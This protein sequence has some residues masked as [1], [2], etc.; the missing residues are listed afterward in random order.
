MVPRA[1]LLALALSAC[2]M[3]R[4][5]PPVPPGEWQGTTAGDVPARADVPAATAYR[6]AWRKGF[7]RGIVTPLQVHPPLLIATTTG[8]RVITINAETG[9]QYW[10]R[11]FNGPIAGAVLRRDDR[12][13]VATG[14]REN[15]FTAL[16]LDRGKKVW[17]SRRVG[18][19]RVQP[20]L[21]ED[22][23]VGVTEG[24]LA[25]AVKVSDGAILWR[26][27]LRAPPGTQPV[28]VGDDILVAT[29]RDTLYRIAASDGRV[30]ARV[31]LPG[32]PSA[33][34]LLLG[35]SLI[36]PVQ[37][38]HV[39]TIDLDRMAAS[40][41]VPL[42]ATVV[43][44]PIAAEDGAAFLL[45][46]NGIV[47]RL[48]AAGGP[49]RALAD[50]GGATAGSFAGVGALLAVGRLDGTL[51]L[52]D[53]A[54]REVWRHDFDDSIEAPVAVRDGALFVPLLRGDIVKLEMQ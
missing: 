12:I 50:V 37:P 24:G 44:R 52:I 51:F 13:Y 27:P 7:G 38:N 30:L 20:I 34:P 42:P 33:S 41:A 28:P 46:R 19:F 29:V 3:P 49:A 8:R 40:P 35:H 11:G 45:A 16:T 10:A 22:R 26:T 18:N 53:R 1:L 47:L 14:D 32:T 17:A 6:I 25:V 54:G 43:A 5:A 39:V 9:A 15:R 2:V 23:L 48:D 4:I 31:A 21:L 36:L